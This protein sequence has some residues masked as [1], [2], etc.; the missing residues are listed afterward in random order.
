M[1]W[2]SG[3]PKGGWEFYVNVATYAGKVGFEEG[4][5]AARDRQPASVNPYVYPDGRPL[6]YFLKLYREWKRGWESVTPVAVEKVLEE[7]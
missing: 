5:Q 2:G 7:C 6:I 1:G 3:T 4:A